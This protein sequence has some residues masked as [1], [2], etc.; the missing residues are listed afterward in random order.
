MR[1]SLE[2]AREI[3]LSLLPES[4]PVVR[5][6]DIA[7][8]SIYCD[9]TGGDYFDFLKFEGPGDR[10]LVVAVGDV[11][12]HGIPSALLMTTARAFIRI[13]SFLPGSIARAV[14]DVNVQLARDLGESGQFMTLF[15]L[16]I[17]PGKKTI[18][19]VRA[20]HEPAVLYDPSSDSFEELMGKGL[21]LG[22]DETWEYEQMHKSG[23]EHGQVLLIA[24][25][26]L[27]EARNAEGK[28][29]G[30][31][32]MRQI[33]RRKHEKSAE[34]ILNEFF[35]LL[36]EFKEG[37]PLEDDVTLVVVRFT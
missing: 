34:E 1:H 15:F 6:L 11:A 26:G 33:I 30:K 21:A 9:R 24:T 22:V 18:K 36:E 25:D 29:L 19:W 27:W 5:G 37:E 3:Q 2:L 10:R 23:I 17:D 20:G 35:T 32:S 14:G 13:R 16:M 28:M 4:A 12:G 8:R 31:E 7:G